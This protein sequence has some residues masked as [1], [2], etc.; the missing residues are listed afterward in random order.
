[1]PCSRGEGAGPS[2][3]RQTGLGRLRRRCRMDRDRSAGSRHRPSPARPRDFDPVVH[4]PGPGDQPDQHRVAVEVRRGV[5]HNP[6][7]VASSSWTSLSSFEV[8]RTRLPG[9]S[10]TLPKYSRN[11]AAPSIVTGP[12]KTAAARSPALA[13]GPLSRAWG[14]ISP[15][16]QS[17][18]A[19]SKSTGPAASAAATN[20]AAVCI[21]PVYW[22]GP[23][24]QEK[25]TPG[26]TDP[27]PRRSVAGN[28]ICQGLK[29]RWPLV[30]ARE[31]QGDRLKSAP[32]PLKDGGQAGACPPDC[33]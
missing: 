8:M 33:L 26:P 19:C 11:Q 31:G 10:R 4:G 28:R 14:R 27:N 1:M 13:L 32:C 16:G 2:T 15:T 5:A 7:A 24:P 23:W 30:H 3:A 6:K 21:P 18:V 20:R 12:E 22:P 17:R 9:P 25:K 29:H